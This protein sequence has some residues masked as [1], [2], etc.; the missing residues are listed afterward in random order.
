[1]MSRKHTVRKKAVPSYKK[2]RTRCPKLFVKIF[3]YM[4]FAYFGNKMAYAYRITEGADFFNKLTG[5]MGNIGSAFRNPLP[6]LNISDLLFG[7]LT[8]VG[9]YAAVY[10]K[11]KNA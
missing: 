3:P 10:L 11:G 8:G 2:L 1:M 6:S 9:V 7:V 4:M 5:C